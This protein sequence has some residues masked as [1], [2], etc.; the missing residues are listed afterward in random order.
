MGDGTAFRAAGVR[1]KQMLRSRLHC[2]VYRTDGR[3][4]FLFG[5]G[6]LDCKVLSLSARASPLRVFG[7]VLAIKYDI[8]GI[9]TTRNPQTVTKR[10]WW[11]S[12]SSRHILPRCARSGG[13]SGC[14][15]SSLVSMIGVCV[16]KDVKVGLV[17]G[18][19]GRRGGN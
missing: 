14:C 2:V 9:Q 12:G 8:V 13:A 7:F 11:C 18:R 5:L 1:L 16:R 10:R 3:T 4:L 15:S 19:A 17:D 6:S